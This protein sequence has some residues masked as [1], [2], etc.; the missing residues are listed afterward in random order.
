MENQTNHSKT[1]KQI[2][3]QVDIA[4]PVGLVP[5]DLFE[6]LWRY[7]WL[8]LLTTAAALAAGLIYVTVATP[9]YTSTSKLYI[10]QNGPRILTEADG[11]TTPSKNCLYTQATLFTSTPILTAAV[12]KPG[13]RELKI[14]QEVDNPIIWLKD[15]GLRVSVG[16]TDDIISVSSDSPDPA[17]A[18]L[19]VNA[20]VEAYRAY[21]AASSR[22]TAGEILNILQN[23]KRRQDTELDQKLKAMMDFKSENIA[24]AFEN[25]NGNVILDKLESLSAEMTQAQ[26]QAVQAKFAFEN[27]KAMMG[28]PIL[29]KRFVDGQRAQSSYLPAEIEWARLEN[30]SEQ[31]ELQLSDQRQTAI[32]DD[33]AVAALRQKV[34]QVQNRLQL[35]YT[36]FAEAQLAAAQQQ[37]EAAKEKEQQI[38]AYFEA[39]RQEAL[40]LNR[41]LAEYRMLESDWEQTKKLCDILD[42][43]IKEIDI[44]EDVGGPNINVLEIA[45]AA[46]KP[47]IP[48]KARC[49]AIALLAGL[50]LAGALA[51]VRDWMDQRLHSVE[52]IAAVLG[53]PIVGSVP[54][55]TRRESAAAR[56]QKVELDSQSAW[57]ESYRTM[58]TAVFFGI[59]KAKGRTILVTSPEAGDGKT[60][61]VSNLAIAMAQAG[62]KTLVLEADFRRPMQHKI[63]G[64]NHHDK[65]LSSVLAGHESPEGAIKSTRI[66]GL[67]LLTCGPDVHNP[68]ETLQS[69]GFEKLVKLLTKQ[70]DRII[71]DSPPVLPVTD[72]QILASICQITLLVLRAEKSTRRASQQARD[73]LVRVGAHV[74]GVVVNDAPNNGHYGCYHGNGYYKRTNGSRLRENNRG[75]TPGK[76]VGV[77]KDAR[78]L[79]C[80][81]N[82][83]LQRIAE[84]TLS[85]KRTVVSQPAVASYDGT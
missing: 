79:V 14:F 76:T 81:D 32:P 57:A 37:Y 67:D 40:K 66:P 56:G 10:E 46:D 28:E 77:A 64:L 25:R 17:Q 71:V 72:A 42:D 7:R 68:S 73:A 60:T 18:A 21:H 45:V 61:V 54:S 62:Q 5:N 31:L 47:S 82:S 80:S 39:Q 11:L 34:N 4:P 27:I 48:A 78:R 35:L 2:G 52:E 23:E 69:A 12:E 29:L 33:A 3:A 85:E 55:A 8:V 24:L 38:A 75:A 9:M 83:G 53:V 51:L 6:V 65:G 59:S 26:I 15:K 70:Y 30:E 63:F 49:I 43:R 36:R 74:F 50:V 16:K 13:I 20:V 22:S 19:L 1:A 41:Q 44:T 84:I 58:R